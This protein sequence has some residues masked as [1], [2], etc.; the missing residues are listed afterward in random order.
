MNNSVFGKTME[1][2]RNRINYELVTNEKRMEK[3]QTTQHIEDEKLL[4]PRI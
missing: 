4:S 2:V 3:H 1:D